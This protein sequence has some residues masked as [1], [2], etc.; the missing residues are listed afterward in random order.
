MKRNCF[1]FS[2]VELLVSLTIIAFVLMT[3][4]MVYAHCMRL[5]EAGR[6]M[7]IATSHAELIL[8]DIRNTAFSQ[9]ETKINNGDWDLNS[10][11]ISALGLTVLNNETA[12]TGCSGTNPLEVWITVNW[13]DTQQRA[14]SQSLRTLISG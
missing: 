7:A 5:N 13:F 1:G 12:D 6:N 9:I 10:T 4:M 3:I 2:L 14:R 11:Q 8:E